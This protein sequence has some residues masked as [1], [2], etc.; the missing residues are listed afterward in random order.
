MRLTLIGTALAALTTATLLAGPANAD[1][2]CRRVCDDG[3]CRSRCVDRGDRLYMYD[4]DS[5]YRDRG[6][7]HRSRSLNL[8]P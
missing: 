8:W 3:F 6:Y 4:R 5:D 2:S 1:R 7:Y